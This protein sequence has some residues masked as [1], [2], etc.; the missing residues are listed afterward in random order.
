MSVELS[1]TVKML[2]SCEDSRSPDA[3]KGLRLMREMSTG[4]KDRYAIWCRMLNSNSSADSVGGSMPRE[5]ILLEGR[6]CLVN[7]PMISDERL[8]R[9]LEAFRA[10][11]ICNASSSGKDRR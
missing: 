1:L 10:R 8:E 5:A 2:P 9:S 11:S 3:S 4:I 7:S 6:W